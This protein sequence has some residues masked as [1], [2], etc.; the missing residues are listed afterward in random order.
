MH[1]SNPHNLNQPM[2]SQRPWGIRVS[3]RKGDPFAGLVGS[4]W[5]REHWYATEHERDQALADMS[6]RYPFFRVGDE[7]ALNFQ[8]TQR[9]RG[10]A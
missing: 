3:L 1:L 7:P 5:S 8:K 2:P 9:H 6:G 10:P 4:D